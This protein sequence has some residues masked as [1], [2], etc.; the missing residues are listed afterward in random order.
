[1]HSQRPRSYGKIN[2]WIFGS[3]FLIHHGPH[4]HGNLRG[5]PPEEIGLIKGNQWLINVNSQS[6]STALFLGGVA[7]GGVPLTSHD[8]GW[9]T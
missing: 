7:L 6:L 3:K 8:I 4:C 5:P 1:M 2:F 9:A